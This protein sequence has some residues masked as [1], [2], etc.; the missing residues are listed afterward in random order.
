MRGVMPGEIVLLRPQAFL[1]FN[2]SGQGVVN[3][4][5]VRHAH[6]FSELGEFLLKRRDRPDGGSFSHK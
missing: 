3:E 5:I 1:S 6:L 4:L 2:K